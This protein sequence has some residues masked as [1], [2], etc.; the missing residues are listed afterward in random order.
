MRAV[1]DGAHGVV[2]LIGSGRQ[3]Y[4]QYL[5]EG[6]SQRRPL[7]LIDPY[8]STWQQPFVVG[9]S[10]VKMLDSARSEADE[11]GLLDSAAE[12]ARNHRVGGVFTYDEGM[13][14]STAR[15]AERLGVP[16][17]T[18]DGADNCRNKHRTRQALTEA[19]L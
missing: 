11:A 19:R 4:R 13:V 16:G 15:I 9:T 17:S 5:L 1:D 3:L 18:V 14:I 8:E 2:L 7:W 10:V 12:V 6:A